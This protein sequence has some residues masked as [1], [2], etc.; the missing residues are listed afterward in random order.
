MILS[1]ININIF[2]KKIKFKVNNINLKTLEDG[3]WEGK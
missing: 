1:S 2:N 3:L